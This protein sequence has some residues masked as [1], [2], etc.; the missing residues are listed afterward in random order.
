VTNPTHVP[1]R[2]W[3]AEVTHPN[4]N[5][6]RPSVLTEETQHLP[7]LKDQPRVNIAVP[8]A[9]VWESNQIEGQAIT[10][11]KD[12]KELP[13]DEVKATRREDSHVV[14]EA[15]GGTEL[16][17]DVTG[18]E[19]PEGASHVAAGDAVSTETSYAFDADDPES[20]TREHVQLYTASTTQDW[21]DRIAD[22]PFADDDPRYINNGEAYCHQT[23]WFIE[24][25]DGDNYGS[26]WTY[27]ADAEGRDGEWSGNSAVRIYSQSDDTLN[28]PFSTDYT[29][30]ADTLS[31]EPCYAMLGTPTAALDIDIKIDING[32]QSGTYDVW[33][34]STGSLHEA[35]DMFDM[36]S[37]RVATVDQEIPPGDH[38]MVI[39]AT[40]GEE[41]F[42]DFVYFFDDCYNYDTGDTNAVN[43]VVDGWQEYPQTLMYTLDP[44]QSVEQVTA[45]S[46]SIGIDD[47][48]GGQAIGLR[49]DQAAS[50]DTASN[51]TTHSA[52]FANATQI[53]QVQVTLSRYRESTT[54]S[55]DYAF[56]RLDSLTLSADLVN[57]PV[58]LD[59]VHEGQLKTGLN[60][61]ADSGGFIWELRRIDGQD[62]IVWTQPG[63]RISDADPGVIDYSAVRTI[64]GSYQRVVARGMS[65][66][67]EEEDFTAPD[68]G[69]LQEFAEGPPLVPGSETVYD[70]SG[71][72]YDRRLDYQ[73]E[74]RGGGI[75][76]LEGGNMTPGDS[77]LVDYQWRYEDEHVEPGVE[78]PDTLRQDFPDASS[79]RECRQ[80]ALAIVREVSDP[81]EEATVT[82]ESVDPTRPLT[83]AVDPDELSIEGPLRIG[84]ISTKP[85]SIEMTLGNRRSSDDAVG[86][87][88]DRLKAL[89][90]SV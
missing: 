50:W 43:E 26:S 18:L 15:A 52:D 5:P 46:A 80:L 12:G 76:I 20:D 27:L 53:A 85:G 11:W 6:L 49:N 3:H 83:E 44:A 69:Q 71:T 72:E 1:T 7:I 37:T 33:T 81:L 56:Q 8:K 61:I 25:E 16:E 88:N 40:D 42:L 22:Y 9:D 4:G 67:V 31:V 78:D 29:I 70:S 51:T 39:T 63:R 82:I 28:I 36:S 14:L 58:V 35:N 41:C 75:R 90:R 19:Y 45:A 89:S 87:L 60:R 62:T 47:T 77:Y 17:Q 59:F 57:V 10:V 86:E 34:G 65:R 68:Y 13:I 2:G 66:G 84:E 73:I 48:S 64:E 79:D 54:T 74:H 24:A 38:E 21:Q 23:A 30:P 55:S 32:S